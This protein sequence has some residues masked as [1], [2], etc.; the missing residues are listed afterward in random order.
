MNF[1]AVFLYWKLATLRVTGKALMALALSITTTLNGAEWSQF[2]PTQKFVGIVTALGAMWLVIDAFLDQTLTQIQQNPDGLG[3]PGA[4]SRTTQ[5]TVTV[6][7]E[8][9]A[10]PHADV[11]LPP[12]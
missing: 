12:P 6:K 1:K 5:Q 11:I 8:V 9:A 2:T 7:T 3:I 4:E 10:T